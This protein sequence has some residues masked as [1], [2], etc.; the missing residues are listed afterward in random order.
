M[1]VTPLDEPQ[2][3]PQRVVIT[4]LGAITPLG[5]DRAE[6]WAG[7]VAG[8]SGIGPI[9][10]FDA[11]G[12][13]FEV[14][15]A[16]EVK[17]FDP[18]PIVSKRDA[19]RMDRVTQL[20]VCCTH[21]ALV[22]AG[23][24]DAKTGQ[25]DPKLASPERTGTYVGTGVGGIGSLI[26]QQDVLRDRGAR[27]VSPF[28]IPMLLGDSVPGSVA[29]QFG[30]KGTNMAHLSA[31]AS[32][33]NSIGEAAEAIRRGA[34]DVMVA[35]GSEAGI[36]PLGVAGFQNMGALSKWQGE[37]ALA[38]RP[39][40]RERDGF[41]IGEGA[42]ILI[43]ESL[44]HAQARGARIYAEIAGYGSTADASHITAPAEGGEGILRAIHAALNQAGLG[45]DAVDYVNAHGTSTPLNDA[46]ETTAMRTLF[47]E[48]A[49]DVP[50]ASIKSMIGHLL[51][52]SG[53]V[54][55]VSS[56]M[57]ITE[58]VIPPTINL[59]TPDPDCD[60]DYVPHTA[61]RPEG[62]IDVVLSNALGFGGHNAALLF[63][64][65]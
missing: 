52:A 15:V 35:G 13:G 39:F 7:L 25:L 56:V 10:H 40:D 32:A 37:P 18:E 9:S 22:D 31:C 12:M 51:G 62:G 49:M 61:R 54:A 63:R 27:R 23:L 6:S 26:E 28:T 58:G 46:T 21:E 3:N 14:S 1:A 50:V 24:L 45:A 36:T 57:S 44:E 42:G 4:G 59:H 16:A 11:P 5:L 29:I 43:L 47:G 30:L 17:D 55:A 38:S 8:R 20:A 60:L 65:F 41:V 2:M 34:V 33:A 64:R 53:A 48:R 19:R